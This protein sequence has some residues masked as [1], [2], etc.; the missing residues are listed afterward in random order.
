MASPEDAYEIT[1]LAYF[2]YHYTYPKTVF[3]YPEMLREALS[4]GSVVS[5]VSKSGD[6]EIAAHFAYLRSPYCREIAE[7]GAVMTRPEYRKSIIALKLMKMVM[8]YP[9][10]VDDSGISL[11]ESNLVTSHTGSQRLARAAKSYPFALKLSVYDH[12]EFIDIDTSRATN[13][14]ESLLYS[15]WAPKGLE[16]PFKIYVPEAHEDMVGRLLDNAGLPGEADASSAEPTA[17][18]GFF[19]VERK[20]EFGLATIQVSRVAAGWRDNLKT[21][22]RDLSMDGF[23]TIHLKILADSPLPADLDERLTEAGFFFSGVMPLTLDRWMLLYTFLNNQRFDFKGVSLC[24]SMAM[25]LR[26]Y[27]ESRREL[28]DI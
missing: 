9:A 16:K 17:E 4:N 8:S 10:R 15:L 24:D 26:D 27:I 5:F 22:R 25:E 6:G 28:V 21:Y 19:D 2:T 11:V 3:Y 7:A 1:K 18:E 13:A 12:A 14:R 20:E 23:A